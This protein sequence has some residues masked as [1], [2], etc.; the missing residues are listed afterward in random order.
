MP[1]L[2]IE[3]GGGDIDVFMFMDYQN[4]ITE[5]KYVNVPPLKFIK[6]ALLPGGTG[7]GRSLSLLKESLGYI[8]FKGGSIQ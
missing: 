7:G 4:N 2:M 1:G 6:P 8:I 5:H 3:R